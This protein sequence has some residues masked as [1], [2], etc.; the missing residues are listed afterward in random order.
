MI[1]GFELII[2]ISKTEKYS[3]KIRLQLFFYFASRLKT[4][5]LKLC[6]IH[7]SLANLRLESAV[8]LDCFTRAD[9][10]LLPKGEE[11]VSRVWV[12][13]IFDAEFGSLII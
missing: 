2:I 4:R 7:F 13:F 12:F 5:K 3:S 11:V 9:W 1:N 10:L 8:F 6:L